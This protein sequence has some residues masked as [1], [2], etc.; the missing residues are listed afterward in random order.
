VKRKPGKAASSSDANS[1]VRERRRAEKSGGGESLST[2]R[3]VDRAIAVLQCFT[4]ETPVMSVLEIQRLVGLSRPTLYRLLQTLAGTGLITAEGDPQRFRLGHGVMHLAH[5]WLSGIKL[6]DVARPI[7]A[8]LR[9]KT[10]ETAALF[11]LQ[12]DHRICVLELE[13][14]HV[15]HIARG[16]G[17][18]GGLVVGA[19][20]KAILAFLDEDRQTATISK[21]LSK[22]RQSEFVS[23][24][25][26]I[27]AQ[28]YATSRSEVILG[29]VAVAAP[30]FNHNGEVT[31]S[32]GVFG[33]TARVNDADV[34]KI[35]RLVVDAAGTL[36]TQLGYRPKRPGIA[37]SAIESPRKVR[38]QP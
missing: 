26:A 6:I 25:K 23:A 8:S 17:D 11:V 5:A 10:G 14:H 15:L 3:A 27:R 13:S 33:P 34:P 32:I 18:R 24:L 16:I 37:A 1:A 4:A 21:A 7:V 2:V 35:A 28:G 38:Q 36:S 31:G 9:E 20:G 30:F 22:A 19:T 12:D 29:A